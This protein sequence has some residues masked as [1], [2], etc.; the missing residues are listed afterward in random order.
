M[1]LI[2]LVLFFFN[3]QMPCFGGDSSESDV[4][5][6]FS[7]HNIFKILDEELGTTDVESS[8]PMLYFIWVTSPSG[9]S[10][11]MIFSEEQ[12]KMLHEV[13]TISGKTVE[14]VIID[15]TKDRYSL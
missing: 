2:D 1:F 8:E 13:A 10:I 7:A 5:T 15:V 12:W 4:S 11:P 9:Y 3:F 6:D 14:D